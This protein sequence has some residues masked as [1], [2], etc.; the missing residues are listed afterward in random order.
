[1]STRTLS[2]S[3]LPV[4]VNLG[5]SLF[6]GSKS[7]FLRRRVVPTLV[8]SGWAWTALPLVGGLAYWG[9]RAWR[10]RA[11]PSSLMAKNPQTPMKDTA[12]PENLVDEAIWESFPASDPPSTTPRSATK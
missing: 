1:M 2:A 4:L 6:P 5:R 12:A 3:A 11:Q 8:R 7:R 9:V 10:N